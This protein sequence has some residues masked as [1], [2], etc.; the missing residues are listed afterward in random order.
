MG[1]AAQIVAASASLP[2]WAGSGQHQTPSVPAS[3]VA[4]APADSACPAAEAGGD[5]PRILND[6]GYN[7][8]AMLQM[9]A[10]TGDYNDFAS[11]WEAWHTDP[12]RTEIGLSGPWMV[13]TSLNPLVVSLAHNIGLQPFSLVPEP[14]ATAL[15]ALGAATVWA[16]RRRRTSADLVQAR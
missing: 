13:Q 10:W 14:S 9:V 2:A 7:S 12:A 11:A 1:A 8:L 6:V 3:V 16:S 5:S 4:G 15:A